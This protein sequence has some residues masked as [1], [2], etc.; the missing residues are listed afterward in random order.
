MIGPDGLCVTRH[1]PN[2]GDHP[3]HKGISLN[4][5]DVSGQRGKPGVNLWD[6]GTIDDFS[7]GRVIHRGFTCLQQGP[8]FI[9]IKEE[10]IW[11]RTMRLRE[12]PQEKCFPKEAGGRSRKRERS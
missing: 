2:F 9:K 3:H 11:N 7:Q 4:L 10:N 12:S 1:V 5:G 6:V 8:V